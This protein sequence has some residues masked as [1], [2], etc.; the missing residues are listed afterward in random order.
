MVCC[1]SLFVAIGCIEHPQSGLSVQSAVFSTLTFLLRQDISLKSTITVIFA[2]M[3]L[4]YA[5]AA[6]LPGQ[7]PPVPGPEKSATAVQG[8]A[9]V[10]VSDDDESD[11][12]EDDAAEAANDEA[13][14][15]SEASL[16]HVPLTSE[17]L[18]D[19]LAADFAYQGGYWQSAYN[20]MMELATKTRDP[21]LAKQAAEIAVKAHHID[22]AMAA[23]KLWH[24]LA[25]E[26]EEAEK[27]Y[28]AFLVL[29]DDLPDARPIFEKRL[30]SAAPGDRGIVILQIQRLL[31]AAKNKPLA[32]SVLEDVLAPYSSMS[33]SHIALSLL[34]FSNGDRARASDEAKKALAIRP[35]SELA[36]LTLAQTLADSS[37]A[38]GVLA[39]FLSSY[40]NSRQVRIAYARML[41]GQKQYDKARVEFEK[42]LTMQP[43]DPLS[44]YSLGILAMQEND[45]RG[46]ERYLNDYLEAL[47]Y[48]QKEDHDVYQVLFLL[49]QIAEEQGDHATA[50]KW[51][52]KVERDSGNSEPYYRAQ[53][54]SAEIMAKQ[55]N[56]N[57]A[58]KLLS[59]LHAETPAEK[60]QIIL[61][62]AQ[63]LREVNKHQESFA[64]LSAGVEQF[65]ENVNLL[66]DY[67]L[68]AE[69]LDKLIVMESSLR[70][71]IA[72]DPANFQAYNALGYS[73]ADRNVRLPEAYALI[74]KALKLAP[75][76][77]FIM[78]SMGW[79]LYRQGKFGEA[80]EKL[81]QAY[82]LR[83]DAEIGVH[84]GEVLWE[85]GQRDEAQK[86]WAEAAK[87]DPKN[88][89]L[90]S[91][92]KRLNVQKVQP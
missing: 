60:E 38:S 91:T 33:E 32:F 70:R 79:V 8:P 6:S 5:V 18:Y 53:F 87:K 63:I 22:K 20:S 24:Q 61:A 11:T 35:D 45:I 77:P 42:L 56:I 21:R 59:A 57:G 51:L 29:G 15:K 78:D 48:Q 81:R 92:L 85:T 19:I 3:L 31:D 1:A 26:S 47:N 2:F 16:P 65:P 34:S 62:E 12:D 64:V 88:E 14:R 74:E 69:K 28:L 40:P 13:A 58:R 17:L 9:P 68:A 89:L 72:L 7:H 27:F 76:D 39:S 82:K 90:K 49:A 84:L 23:T 83:P 41:I 36:I 67:A 86:L 50:L 80:E 10:A 73:L 55:G 54:K 66:Y 75:N 46:A 52:D 71:I 4:N 30:S 37:D 25:P 44:L 43:H